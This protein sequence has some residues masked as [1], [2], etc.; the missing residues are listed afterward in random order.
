[1]TRIQQALCWAAVLILL[2]T[3]S[4]L[5][6]VERDTAQVLF[7]VLPVV[8]WMNISGRGCACLP[9]DGQRA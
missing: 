5:G 7:I 9:Q 3:G 1:M 2:A 6:L 4:A 8:A